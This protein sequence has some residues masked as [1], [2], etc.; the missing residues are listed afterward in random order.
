MGWRGDSFATAPK[1]R[2]ARTYLWGPSDAARTARHRGVLLL[3]LYAARRRRRHTVLSATRTDSRTGKGPPRRAKARPEPLHTLIF[4]KG[5]LHRVSFSR[6]PY[7][8]IIFPFSRRKLTPPPPRL[9]PGPSRDS[10]IIYI[11][12]KYIAIVCTAAGGTGGTRLCSAIE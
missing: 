5:L 7:F 9:P 2:D 11:K 10:R 12:T 8:Q 3:L 1:T 6:I 4:P